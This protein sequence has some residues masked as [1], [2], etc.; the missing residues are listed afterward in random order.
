MADMAPVRVEV[1]AV[2][3]VAQAVRSFTEQEQ[4]IITSAR[5]EIK[6]RGDQARTAV[7]HRRQALERARQARAAA[8]S[9]LARCRENCAGLARAADAA[10][11]RQLEAEHSL[12]RA[13]Q[14]V[15]V[16]EQAST[17]LNVTSRAVERAVAEHGQA[18]TV[19]CREL[20]AK[21]RGF[22]RH[23]VGTAEVMTT[24]AHGASEV[25]IA[26]PQSFLAPANPST[27]ITAHAEDSLEEQQKLWAD[28]Q[29]VQ[30][31]NRPAPKGP[32]E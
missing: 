3:Q 32:K 8:D 14:A 29:E 5:S 16:L 10:R 18:A 7:Q 22:L 25:G 24:I 4:R 20:A 1:A 9:A 13:T 31:K 27:S 15:Q 12:N 2:E 28:S 19:A 30:R 21:L 23:A 11:R 6:R 17:N 26:M